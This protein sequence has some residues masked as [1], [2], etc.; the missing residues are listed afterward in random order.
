[1][2]VKLLKRWLPILVLLAIAWALKPKLP[3]LRNGLSIATQAH[4]LWIAFG[5]GCACAALAAMAAVMVV[6]L[7]AGGLKVRLA[8]ALNLVLAANAWSATIPG[9]QA[10]AA[11]FS[12]N[13]MTSWGA[14]KLLATW[15]IVVSGAISTAWLVG[16]SLTTMLLAGADSNLTSLL[17]AGSGMVLISVAL[18]WAMRHPHKV[19]RLITPVL[20][21]IGQDPQKSITTAND[22]AAIKLTYPQFVAA[23]TCSLLNW[24]FDIA[25]LYFSICAVLN[26]AGWNGTSDCAGLIGISQLGYG[27]SGVECDTLQLPGNRPSSD[28]PSAISLAGVAL[29]FISAKVAGTIQ[30]T[31]GGL[32]PVEAALTTALLATGLPATEALAA[33]LI[34]RFITLIFISAVGWL[35]WLVSFKR[36][37]DS[38]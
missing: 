11:L 17:T 37:S 8:K 12:F 31:P 33:T 4:P 22:V 38:S 34:Y 7:R 35:A 9:G 28:A 5:I 27:G 25:V 18:Y 1:M 36:P 30:T 13:T 2:T 10:F 24:L 6:L 19:A 23:A 29:A 26:A 21:R 14:T 20:K 15:Q 3:L 16:L 32:G